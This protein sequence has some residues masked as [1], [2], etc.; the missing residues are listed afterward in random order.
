MRRLIRAERLATI[1]VSVIVRARHGDHVI[2]P[3]R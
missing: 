1:A 3:D 2:V